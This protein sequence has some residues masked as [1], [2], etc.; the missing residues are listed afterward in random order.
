MAPDGQEQPR[1]LLADRRATGPTNVTRGNPAGPLGQLG[2][3]ACEGEVYT[4]GRVLPSSSGPGGGSVPSVPGLLG[5]SP[6]GTVREDL[7]P[8]PWR[9]SPDGPMRGIGAH[10]RPDGAVGQPR[11]GSA[12]TTK[13]DKQ[14]PNSGNTDHSING[15]Y[16]HHALDAQRGCAH[17]IRRPEPQVQ[18]RV[19]LV[20]HRARGHRHLIAHP[21][22]CHSCRPSSCA[23][24]Y[25]GST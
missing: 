21:L 17:Q 13:W 4:S 20:Q 18:R 14:A 7:G 16:Q 8:C 22:H 23:A 15:H 3:N 9:G 24:S 2:V 11:S 12:T 6:R 5:E 10:V 25:A 19:G 1:L